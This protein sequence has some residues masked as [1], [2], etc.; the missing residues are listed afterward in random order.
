MLQQKNRN[1][2]TLIFYFTGRRLTISRIAG[3]AAITRLLATPAVVHAI[4]KRM[5]IMIY[6]D[7]SE[8]LTCPSSLKINNRLTNNFLSTEFGLLSK[9]Q[10]RQIFLALELLVDEE[11]LVLHPLHVRLPL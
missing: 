10:Q 4:Q 7:W 1:H 8:D 2:L 6:H 11:I 5:I 3:I 9:N